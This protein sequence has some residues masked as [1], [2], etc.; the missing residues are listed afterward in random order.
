[1]EA[2]IEPRAARRPAVGGQVRRWRAERKLTLAQVAERTGLNIGYLSQI[3]ND[4]ALPSL[5]CLASLGEAL[6]VPVAWF[7]IDSVPP[8]VV[9]RSADRPTHPIGDRGRVE[10]V[11]GSRSRRTSMVLIQ[12]PPGTATG[13]HT[14]GGEEHHLVMRGHWRLSQG[15][16]IV[17][18]DPGDYIA[19][20]GTIPH[21]AEVTGE[22]DGEIL[23]VSVR[24]DRG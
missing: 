20:D 8:P 23:I 15:D 6:D 11:D 18:A 4:K 21:D 17:E 24:T 3:E 7:L 1:M 9:I 5:T 2:N 22:E 16:H 14:H 19:W 12:V 10:I 13:A